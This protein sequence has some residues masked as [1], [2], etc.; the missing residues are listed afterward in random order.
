M[1]DKLTQI[2]G[3][4]AL[5]M[6]GIFITHTAVWF[7]DDLGAFARISGRFGG[8]GVATFL[9]LSGFLLAYKQKLIPA[10]ERRGVIKAAWKKAS[11]L[12]VLYLITFF[13][14][15]LAR[16]KFPL[17]AKDWLITS[18]SAAFNLTMTQDFVP[19]LGVVNAFNGPSWFLSAL[20]GIW[21]LIYLFPKSVNRL[22]T[23]SVGKCIVGIIALLVIQELWVFGI[24]NYLY[25]LLT[26]KHVAW[27]GEWLVYCNPIMCFSEF[28]V[29]VLLG[30]LCVQKQLSVGAQNVMACVTLFVV[31]VYAALLMTKSLHVSV[32]KIV[33][34]ELFACSGLLAIMSPQAIGHRMLS[35]RPLVW[36]GDV[37]GYMFLIHGAVNFAIGASIVSYIPKPGLFFVSLTTSILLSAIADYIYTQKKMKEIVPQ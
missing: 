8:A 18:I 20:F 35:V 10:I 31:V 21:I 25:P 11:K 2:Q 28:C 4:R 30:R 26:P 27:F 19:F 9:I 32:S 17:S 13:V 7:S 36:L 33:I 37:S 12:Y 16:A 22:M 6:L 15:F 5:A 14:A 3:V 34:A 24:K 29:G 23:L 1:S